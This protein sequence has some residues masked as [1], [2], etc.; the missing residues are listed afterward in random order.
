MM[1]KIRQIGFAIVAALAVA[2]T[3]G[4]AFAQGERFEVTSIKAVRPTLVNTIAALQARDVARAK[5]AFEAYDS[6]WNGIEVYV[7]VR[8]KPMYE[9]L[10]HE[11]QARITKALDAPNPQPRSAARGRPGDAGQ[12]RRDRRPDRAAAATQSALRRNCTASHRAR[13]PAR[14]TA[15]LKGWRLRQGA[16]VLPDLRRYLG[17]HRRPDKGA[18]RRLL[19]GDR[20]RHDRHRK[21][22]DA[23]QARRC[24]SHRYGQ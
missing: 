12:I 18:Q 7:N 14:S 17:Q 8:S 10:E 19:C 2:G 24:T 21:G 16:E 20:E 6:A 9:T 1:Q 5:A 23:Q 11:F 3:A 4:Q 13:T 15:R 22:A